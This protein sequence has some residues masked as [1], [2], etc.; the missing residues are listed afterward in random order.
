MTPYLSERGR[1]V[2]ASNQGEVSFDVPPGV[3]WKVDRAAIRCTSTVLTPVLSVY[4]GSASDENLLDGSSNGDLDFADNNSP[5]RVPPGETLR[6]VW[7][8]ADNGAI[9][10]AMI[11]GEVESMGRRAPVSPNVLQDVIPAGSFPVSRR[12]RK[13][14]Q[15]YGGGF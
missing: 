15:G 1:V 13:V 10:S 6:L 7:R 4:L 9:A 11:F 3:Y 12:R 8:N 14:T 5:W 2:I